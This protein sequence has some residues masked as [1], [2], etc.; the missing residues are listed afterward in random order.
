MKKEKQLLIGE[1][2]IYTDCMYLLI[3]S[4]L[5]TQLAHDR[6]HLHRET[7]TPSHTYTHTHT[8]VLNFLQMKAEGSSCGQ[9]HFTLTTNE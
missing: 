6:T 3:S 2:K 4:R 5:C 7:H 1:E 8:Q 9:K